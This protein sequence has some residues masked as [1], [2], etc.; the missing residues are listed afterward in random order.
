MYDRNIKKFVVILV[1]VS[2]NFQIS[3]TFLMIIAVRYALV[4]Y[5]NSD[6]VIITNQLMFFF[7]LLFFS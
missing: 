1:I 3:C 2:Y 7:L 6:L 4:E 5:Y